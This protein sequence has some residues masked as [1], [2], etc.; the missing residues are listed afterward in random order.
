MKKYNGYKNKTKFDIS[1]NPVM[2]SKYDM[3]NHKFFIGDFYGYI[4]CYDLNNAI[5]ELNKNFN[6]FEEIFE[7]FII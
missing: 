6:T 7:N 2:Y 5:R 1:K 4:A 3:N